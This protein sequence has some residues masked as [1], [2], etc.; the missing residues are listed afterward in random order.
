[1]A[2]PVKKPR[3]ARARRM[4]FISATPYLARDQSRILNG[5]T[6]TLSGIIF[7]IFPRS[8]DKN[9]SFSAKPSRAKRKDSKLRESLDF[10]A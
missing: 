4:R 8:N 2:V 1:M 6:W 9:P 5:L 7:L 3:T 10:A